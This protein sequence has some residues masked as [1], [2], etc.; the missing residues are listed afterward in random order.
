MYTSANSAYPRAALPFS[1]ALGSVASN[2]M[3]QPAQAFLG[4]LGIKLRSAIPRGHLRLFFS[5]LQGR[6]FAPKHI[7]D[8][9][10]NHGK[11]TRVALKYFPDAYYTLIEPQDHLRA[12]VAD[13]LARHSRIRWVGAGASD[14]SGSLPFTMFSRDDRSSFTPTLERAKANDMR[15]V[16][17]PVTTLNEI[18]RTGDAPI[19]DMVK[20]DAEG[21][22][23]RVLA[24]ASELIGKTDIF[25]LEAAICGDLMTRTTGS[26]KVFENSL[27]KV[28]ETMAHAGY[29]ILDITDLNRSPK[30]KALW[31]C[32]V[33][34]LRNGSR[35]LDGIHSFD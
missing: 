5:M 16:E 28:I 19:P 3:K 23:L 22:D 6:S 29:R 31:L 10:A 24:G 34:F 26:G 9:G 7:I 30:H 1:Q 33:A 21:F 4:N 8:V 18:V 15:Q 12:H 20:I 13:L 17:I 2:D 32:E 25:L 11:W 27:E 35:I 14:T